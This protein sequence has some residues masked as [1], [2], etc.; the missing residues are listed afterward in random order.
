MLLLQQL[1]RQP[2]S[3]LRAE[4]RRGQVLLE[5]FFQLLLSLLFLSLLLK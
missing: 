4:R 1:D 5:L 2:I 3:V